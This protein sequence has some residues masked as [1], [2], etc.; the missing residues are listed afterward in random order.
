MLQQVDCNG[1]LL[2][3]C[4]ETAGDS[5]SVLGQKD[6]EHIQSCVGSTEIPDVCTQLVSDVS[7]LPTFPETVSP[8]AELG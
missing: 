2:A 6:S 4:C 5:C 1:K 8:L 3:G 7:I